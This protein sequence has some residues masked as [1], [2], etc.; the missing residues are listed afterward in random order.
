MHA[1]YTGEL[2]SS[3]CS[4]HAPNMVVC[5]V[6]VWQ[7]LGVAPSYDTCDAQD[8]VLSHPILYGVYMLIILLWR[9]QLK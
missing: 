9:K 8:T 4:A 3:I 6:C 5:V 7:L 1:T 2:L